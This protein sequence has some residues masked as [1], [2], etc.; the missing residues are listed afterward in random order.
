MSNQI[1]VF[2]AQL[3]DRGNPEQLMVRV[4]SAANRL[5]KTW[6]TPAWPAAANPYR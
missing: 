1:A 4:M 5:F 6:A 2:Y 3:V